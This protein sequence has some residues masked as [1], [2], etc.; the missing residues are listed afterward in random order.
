MPTEPEFT[1]SEVPVVLLFSE[2]AFIS[3]VLVTIGQAQGFEVHQ[4]VMS[5]VVQFVTEVNGA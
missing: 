1:D 3:A 4:K 2:W 5:Q